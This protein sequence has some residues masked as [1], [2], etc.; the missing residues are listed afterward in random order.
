MANKEEKSSFSRAA[1]QQLVDFVLNHR[2]IL[3]D[4]NTSRKPNAAVMRDELWKEISVQLNN[5]YPGLA[6]TVGSCSKHWS[7][8]QSKAKK[9][10]TRILK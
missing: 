6:C 5:D 1:S 9:L 4:N 3:V 8:K 2:D 7:Y 10:N